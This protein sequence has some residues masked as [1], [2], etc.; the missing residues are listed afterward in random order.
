MA[1]IDIGDYRS[2]LLLVLT[3]ILP[4]ALQFHS[5]RH[6]YKISFNLLA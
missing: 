1:D 6:L 5:V 2:F 4:Y 3:P